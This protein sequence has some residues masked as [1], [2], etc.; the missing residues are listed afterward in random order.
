MSVRTDKVASLVKQEIGSIFQRNFSMA[1]YGFLTVTE[2][3][4]SP[5]L[6][7]AK[8]YVSVFGN[9]EQKRASMDL[10]EG[11]KGFIRAELGHAV[12]LKFTPTLLFFLDESLDRAMNIE[13][14]LNKIHKEAAKGEGDES[15]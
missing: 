2:V 1:E 4:M 11:Q 12:R 5:D 15:R 6:K 10:L 13:S 14:I 7:I 3:R 8:V 9:A